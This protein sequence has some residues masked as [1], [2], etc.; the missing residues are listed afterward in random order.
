LRR[1]CVFIKPVVKTNEKTQ[2]LIMNISNRVLVNETHGLLL[3][4]CPEQV[5]IMSP[6]AAV[7]DGVPIKEV[8]GNAVVGIVLLG[9][10]LSL[11]YWIA[12]LLTI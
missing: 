4:T 9:G 5:Q 7:S 1:P 11:P 2:V 3:E 12:G 6:E 8:I 10:L